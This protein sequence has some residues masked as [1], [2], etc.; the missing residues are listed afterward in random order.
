MKI[1]SQLRVKKILLQAGSHYKIDKENGK[2]YYKRNGRYKEIKQNE[3]GQIKLSNLKRGPENMQAI[4]VLKCVIWINAKGIIPEGFV[5]EQ[6]DESK[7]PSFDNLKIRERIFS[8]IKKRT[9]P[10]II[11][12]I[13][14][15]RRKGLSINTIMTCL[16]VTESVVRYQL[17]K[18]KLL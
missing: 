1:E 18:S 16:N 7:P 15:L 12:K 6:I 3:K 5:I 2:V 13:R 10:E 17:K 11:Y 14:N 4:A 9:E 8:T